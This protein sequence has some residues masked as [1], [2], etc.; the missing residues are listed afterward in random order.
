[1][2]HT[3]HQIQKFFRLLRKKIKHKKIEKI[4]LLPANLISNDQRTKQ[5]KWRR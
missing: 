2:E 3:H 1:M 5:S 4:K